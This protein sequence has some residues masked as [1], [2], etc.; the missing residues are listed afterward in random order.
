ML[1]VDVRAFSQLSP[2]GGSLEDE[3]A[4]LVSNPECSIIEFLVV[5]RRTGE[6]ERGVLRH[7]APSTSYV[8]N[9][10]R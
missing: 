5:L 1:M 4:S 8:V 2:K 10:E 7:Q 3:E 6:T 9:I